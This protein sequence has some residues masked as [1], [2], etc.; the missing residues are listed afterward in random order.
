M[1]RGVAIGPA[2]RRDVR[3]LGG[4]RQQH[5]GITKFDELSCCSHYAGLFNKPDE[6]VDR[7]NRRA[8]AHLIGLNFALPKC[9]MSG[10][11]P[12]PLDKFHRH[13]CCVSI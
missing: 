10:C 9:A 8:Q 7:V 6:I 13:R 11:C 2:D 4:A 3:P 1:Q 5:E 12:R